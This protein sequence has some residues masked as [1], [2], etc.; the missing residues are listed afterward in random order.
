MMTLPRTGRRSACAILVE[1]GPNLAV[2][3]SAD[4]LAAWAGLCPSN[5]KSTKTPQRAGFQGQINAFTP[6]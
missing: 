5:N 6:S 1:I 4:R 3:D 2:L